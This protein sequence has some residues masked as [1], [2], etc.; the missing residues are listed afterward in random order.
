[1]TIDTGTLSGTGSIETK[2]GLNN[3]S[4]SISPGNLKDPISSIK[5]IGNLNQGLNSKII[6]NASPE[7]VDLLSITGN[8]I[9]KGT[10][11]IKSLTTKKYSGNSQYEL[12]K[13]NNLTGKFNNFYIEDPSNFGHLI[14]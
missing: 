7:E 13:T 1:M 4:G 12:I 3:F 8:T 6:I 5:I 11:S 9:L 10:L 14:Q 2:A